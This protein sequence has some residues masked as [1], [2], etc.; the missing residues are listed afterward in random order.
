MSTDALILV[1][2]AACAHAAWNIIAHGSSRS[3][4][5]FLFWGAIVSTLLWL[6]VV[7]F[8]GGLG[9][10]GWR[11]LL[12]GASVSAL[13]HVGYMV[14]LQRGYA[15][16]ELSTVYATARG[17]GPTLTVLV[18]VLFLG[19]Q[20]TPL[21]LLGVG[22]VIVGVIA[23]GVIGRPPRP[24]TLPH[25]QPASIGVP[26]S[27]PGRN[28]SLWRLLSLGRVD[29]A[30]LF[31]LATGV[32]I[33]AYT[34]WDTYALREWQVSP[35]ALMV[36]CTAFEVPLLAALAWRRRSELLPTIRE[37]WRRLLAFGALSPLSYIL[38]LVAVTIAPVSLVAPMREVSVVLVSLF[39]AFV[40]REHRPVQ[41]VIAS[42]A[43]VGGA[44]L[45]S[46]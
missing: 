15:A 43:V 22:V 44:F 4:V 33:A 3:G 40:G 9:D 13:L 31:G 38:V 46:M 25:S 10:G 5:P 37:Q 35:V 21:A 16:G 17:T 6:P 34:V 14:L 24:I 45:L 28:N 8:T 1:L 42:A 7:P 2:I 19:E 20:P 36:G 26:G 41:R 23:M 27:A 30:L 11:G 18:A 32:A 39:G 12:L 29:P